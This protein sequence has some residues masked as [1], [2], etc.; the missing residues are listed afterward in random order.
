[1]WIE[2]RGR[3]HRVYYRTGLS[4]PARAFEPFGTR[5]QAEAFIQ[6]ARATSLAGAMS[7]ARNPSAYALR[8]LFG[9]PPLAAAA[10]APQRS[11][12]DPGPAPAPPAAPSGPEA[13]LVGLTFAQL[14][15]R[16]LEAQRHLEETTAEDYSSY[17]NFHLLPFFGDLDLGLIYRSRAL[18]ERDAAPGAVYVDDWVRVMLAKP[19]CNSAGRPTAGT[20]LS[21]KFMKNVLTVLAQCFDVA[22]Q[23][24]PALLEVNPAREIRLPKQDRRELHFLEDDEAYLALRCHMHAH[25]QP[26]LDFLVGT[27]ARSVR[28]PGS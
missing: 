21:I 19:R 6:L 22:I 4:S 27:G 13:H 24:R 23:A 25:F 8:E 14:W 20:V 5:D 1:M 28:R 16:F 15:A 12:A 7:Y 2:Q 10:V 26:V 9:L 18:R 3:Q 17:G 11:L